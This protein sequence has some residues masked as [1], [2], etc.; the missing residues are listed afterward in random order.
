[1]DTL[2]RLEEEQRQQRKIIEQLVDHQ[3]PSSRK[4]IPDS[5]TIEFE[6]SFTKFLSSFNALPTEERQNKIQKAINSI[7]EYSSSLADFITLCTMPDTN[8]NKV[9]LLLNQILEE[10]PVNS[11]DISSR[12][13]R[14][15]LENIYPEYTW[16]SE[17]DST[18]SCI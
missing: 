7:P 18:L 6:S 13:E 12:K 5:K 16:S 8:N 10:F 14:E 9:P 3:N 1:L 11:V 17:S 4:K 2:Q 15:S